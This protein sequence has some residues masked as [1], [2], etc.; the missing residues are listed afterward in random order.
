MEEIQEN[1]DKT[2]TNI[3]L[4]QLIF[5]QKREKLKFLNKI[6]QLEKQQ[7]M[8]NSQV[9]QYR[10]ETDDQKMKIKQFT[11][12]IVK[13][14]LVQDKMNIDT[15]LE[16]QLII[17]KNNKSQV[18]IKCSIDRNEAKQ[19]LQQLGAKNKNESLDEKFVKENRDFGYQDSKQQFPSLI[20]EQNK[21]VVVQVHRSKLKKM[22]SQQ[23]E[24]LL[25][26]V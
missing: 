13:Q 7:R 17:V 26:K 8:L 3:Q 22:T 16:R 10:R 25:N 11:N 21:L 15:S 20:E 18:F 9:E 2:N 12:L 14:E 19:I 5:Q 24:Q 23:V 1:H 4:E 6:S